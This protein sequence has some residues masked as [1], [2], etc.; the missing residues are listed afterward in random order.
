MA[1]IGSDG[2]SLLVGDGA[3]TET[4]TAL[5]GA[6]LA[7]FSVT[8]RAHVASAIGS[9][10]WLVQQ[11]ASNRQAVIDCTAYATDEA[12]ALRV[13]SLAL[14]GLTGNFKL[15]LRSGQ[16]LSLNAVVTSY[17]ETIAQGDIKTVKF[18]LESNGDVSLG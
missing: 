9:D 5:K 12:P 13:Q 17:A 1:L 16:T 4:F 14:S 10:A 8:Q 7:Q 15:E 2:L 3:G 11:G 6:S 18:R